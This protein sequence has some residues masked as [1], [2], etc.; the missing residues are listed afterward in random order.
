MSNQNETAGNRPGKS[1]QPMPGEFP[2]PIIQSDRESIYL[3][4]LRNHSSY[5]TAGGF[6][7]GLSA[8][9]VYT[10]GVFGNLLMLLPILLL[11][12]GILGGLHF[13]LLSHTLVF[14]L[15][16]M[17]A[18]IALSL[19]YFAARSGDPRD[20][21]K[22][23]RAGLV[24]YLPGLV[25]GVLCIAF[26]IELSPRVIEFFRKQ[27]PLDSFGLAE[28]LSVVFAIAGAAG[29][30][31]KVFPKSR[32]LRLSVGSG[33]LAILGFVLLWVIVLCIAYYLC[34]GLPPVGWKIQI[35]PICVIVLVVAL[36]VAF[37]R[38]SEWSLVRRIGLITV[39][40][41]SG[42]IL[43]AGS[44]CVSNFLR[45]K[46]N[47]AA[48]SIGD[49]T[50]PIGQLINGISEVQRDNTSDRDDVAT[51]LIDQKKALDL[52]GNLYASRTRD[53]ADEDLDSEGKSHY[54][55]FL[56]WIVESSNTETELTPQY[57]AAAQHFLE[58]AEKLTSD[59]P[60]NVANLRQELGSIA[61]KRVLSEHA[62]TE[63]QMLSELR[64]RF[65]QS[66]VG[67][68]LKEIPDADSVLTKSA[69]ELS[70]WTEQRLPFDD[71]IRLFTI[72][73]TPISVQ[74]NLALAFP[75][76]E[77]NQGE[78]PNVIAP[79]AALTGDLLFDGPPER[80]TLIKLRRLAVLRYLVRRS[81]LS[82][83]E[84]RTILSDSVHSQEFLEIDDAVR[85]ATVS[86]FQQLV[87]Q[88]LRNEKGFDIAGVI[89][90]SRT[91]ADTAT[92]HSSTSP[93][94]E[95]SLAKT[96]PVTAKAALVEIA[97]SKNHHFRVAASHVLGELYD[98]HSPHPRSLPGEKKE[99]AALASA[100]YERPPGSDFDAKLLG[101]ILA[102][103]LIPSEKNEADYLLRRMVHGS[104]G[105]LDR[106][107]LVSSELFESTWFA[108]ALI[109][110][111]L[112]SIA[113]VF[114]FAFVNPNYTSVHGFYRDRLADAFLLTTTEDGKVQPEC[115]VR[116][117]TLCNYD[118]GKSTAPYHLIN[119]ALNMQ[120][121]ADQ[122]VRD[123]KADFVFFSRLF[124]GGRYVNFIR[125]EALEAAAPDLTAASAMAISAGAAAPNMGKYTSSLLSFLLAVI[126]VR[127]GHWIPNPKRLQN[128]SDSLGASDNSIYV[129]RFE[130]V[131]YFE[132][133]EIQKRRL[134]AGDSRH[135]FAINSNSEESSPNFAVPSVKNELLGVALSGGG[136]RSA[137]VNLGLLQ[138]LDQYGLLPSVDYL[139]TVSG[140]GYLGTAVSTFMR[141][142][143]VKTVAKSL[144]DPKGVTS[145]EPVWL[146]QR[147]QPRF[148]LFY[149]EMIS[150]LNSES[151]WI[152]LSDGGHIENLGVYEL[153]RRRCTVIIAGDGEEDKNGGFPGLSCLVRLAAIDL[154]IKIEFPTGDLS[155]LN[156][157]GDD[158]KRQNA[159]MLSHSAVAR[160]VYPPRPEIGE[161]QPEY[162]FL[163]YIRSSIGTIEADDVVIKGYRKVDENFPHQSTVDQNFD[164]VQF[165]AYR[166][167]GEE[168]AKRTLQALD[169]DTI[170]ERGALS[171][172]WLL[173]SLR[174]KMPSSRP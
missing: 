160:I 81:K 75:A 54:Q 58:Q 166:R 5:L 91:L 113:I 164:E 109:L 136:I 48:E 86:Q 31:A 159:E 28:C 46:T 59:D 26:A 104:H 40:I 33:V 106:L 51:K 9:A 25:I 42:L 117:S 139:S 133:L 144:Q 97:L 145:P 36:S 121:T 39:T 171:Y 128:K 55:R 151:N 120:W 22:R 49:I 80:E 1:E 21:Q 110:G 32:E 129:K 50:R 126:N 24:D 35:T 74:Q 118:D 6:L 127:L 130:T 152:N 13:W 116:I 3:T 94:I 147:W 38:T 15:G 29:T 68:Q 70:E 85:V 142:K 158:K 69:S 107:H 27:S 77:R 87:E 119:T 149:R 56:A 41:V 82:S 112:W 34:Y 168:M 11:V 143:S 44:L 102:D 98:P 10:R 76:R 12:G 73:R 122:S 154:G 72:Q 92:R 16:V 18:A 57:Y 23:H 134:N 101:P 146:R 156:E 105:N 7:G 30:I 150:W 108:R 90:Q 71:L 165:E 157:F 172:D 124:V 79:D 95:M 47:Y 53:D 163:L 169:S 167:L 83:T 170:I 155:K 140:G 99:Q 19:L 135:A 64:V 43:L 137:S 153:L 162:G 2:F 20:Q 111:V 89:S 60:V 8:I 173:A 45:E 78:L 161:A 115:A 123:R 138:V 148:W 131:F 66:V 103:R 174:D 52:A 100:I 61:F 14:T 114:C 132:R 4:W 84:L 67:R 62:I 93:A 63:S 65:V 96:S 37:F 125:T 17:L 141:T 88:A